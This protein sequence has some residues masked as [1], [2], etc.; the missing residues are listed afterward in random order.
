M[1]ADE[2]LVSAAHEYGHQPA[3]Y[4]GRAIHSFTELNRKAD[5]L[6]AALADHGVG[7]GAVVAAFLDEGF[8]AIVTL[9]GVLRA[10]GVLCPV[11]PS[12]SARD[13][14]RI[15]AA[16]GTVGIVTESR[17]A[18]V[19]ATAL[20]EASG[21]RLVIVSGADRSAVAAGCL[22][23]GEVVG[24]LS[25]SL[26][27]RAVE[28]D[29]TAVEFPILSAEGHPTFEALTHAALAAGEAVADVADE[30][31]A[32]ISRPFASRVSLV[33]FVATLRHGR[34]QWLHDERDGRKL[35]PAA[36]SFAAVRLAL[37]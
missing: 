11:A 10:G 33:D 20:A 4:V 9:F 21:V 36:S 15:L 8:P 25:G 13:L 19:A 30:G 14:A 28:A 12:T 31:A 32:G 27:S 2:Y 37:A 16:S 34:P 17:L 3:V 18:S 7:R 24:A 6:A 5:R 22:S 23:F 1:R 35:R 29:A 26:D